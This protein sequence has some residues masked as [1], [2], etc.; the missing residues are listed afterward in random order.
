MNMFITVFISMLMGGTQNLKMKSN[1]PAWARKTLC[2]GMILCYF[3]LAALSV[4]ILVAVSEVIIR[5][6]MLV[7]IGLLIFIAVK[8]TIRYKRI[9][10]E[11]E[12]ALKER[13]S[14]KE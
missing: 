9:K 6:L 1:V 7:L 3:L 14:E 4:F 11:N 2:W 12:Q 10:K 8:F 5:V 13:E